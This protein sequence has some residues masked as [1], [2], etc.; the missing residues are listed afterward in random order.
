MDAGLEALLSTAAEMELRFAPGWCDDSLSKREPLPAVKEVIA[1]TDIGQVISFLQVYVMPRAVVAGEA[2]NISD[3]SDF[4]LRY[5]FANGT[6]AYHRFKD[7]VPATEKGLQ[8]A[9]ALFTSGCSTRELVKRA[10]ASGYHYITS[11]TGRDL[12][13]PVLDMA[14]VVNFL[15]NGSVPKMKN[16]Q[17]W[18][19]WK[20]AN[21]T[22]LEIE[23]STEVLT[24]YYELLNKLC[25]KFFW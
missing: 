21:T 14:A 2:G 6:A 24:E 9:V 12:F 13:E 22:R 1:G 7:D 16:G 15:K 25:A 11:G 3:L 23:E 18:Q 17:P 8:Y 5:I 20:L 19:P 10:T 4:V